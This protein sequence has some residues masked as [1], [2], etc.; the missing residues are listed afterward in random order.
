MDTKQQRHRI[1]CKKYR[2]KNKEKIKEYHKIYRQAK[3]PRYK[4]NKYKVEAKRKSNA[5][6]L[7]FDEFDLILKQE[8]LYCGSNE[9]IGIDRL[10][11]NKGYIENNCVPCCQTCNYMKRNYSKDFFIKH[12]KKIIKFNET[13]SDRCSANILIT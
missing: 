2:N 7:S 5:F 12:C 9:K 6:E 4:Y 11:N 13:H 10:N 8:C 1:A 3:S